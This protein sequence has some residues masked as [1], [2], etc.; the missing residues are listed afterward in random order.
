MA[1]LFF[2]H[3]A[4]AEKVYRLV[5]K[6]ITGCFLIKQQDGT[7]YQIQILN[8]TRINEIMKNTTLHTK[9]KLGYL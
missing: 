3:F 5:E 1:L 9:M 2:D 8:F 7:D 4:T 6:V